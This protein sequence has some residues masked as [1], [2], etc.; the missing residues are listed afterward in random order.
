[1]QKRWKS[2]KA[3]KKLKNDETLNDDGDDGEGVRRYWI[4]VIYWNMGSDISVQVL[5][6]EF[7]KISENPKIRKSKIRNPKIENPKIRKSKIRNPKIEESEI[8]KPQN[9]ST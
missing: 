6:A 9:V 8:Q 3:M 2:E 7:V 1:M 4:L 5:Y